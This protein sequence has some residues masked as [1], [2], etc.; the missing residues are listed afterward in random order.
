MKINV[1]DYFSGIP[2]LFW[3]IVLYFNCGFLFL[4]NDVDSYCFIIYVNTRH[5][6][7]SFL[8]KKFLLFHPSDFTLSKIL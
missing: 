1:D 6:F 3:E 8:R 2:A 7:Y 5:H 4:D